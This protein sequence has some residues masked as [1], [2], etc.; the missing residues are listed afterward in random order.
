MA[1]KS[2]TMRKTR[3]SHGQIQSGQANTS[4]VPTSKLQTR[5]GSSAGTTLGAHNADSSTRQRKGLKQLKRKA[6][7]GT[8]RRQ[9][10]WEIADESNDEGDKERATKR[11]RPAGAIAPNPSPF[12][13]R[14]EIPMPSDGR[15]DLDDH[16]STPRARR[17]PSKP[18]T[19]HMPGRPRR[20][21]AANAP[22]TS[23]LPVREAPGAGYVEERDEVGDGESREQDDPEPDNLE[24]EAETSQH[25]DADSEEGDEA[26]GHGQQDGSGS[27]EQDDG[28]AE[29]DQGSA[30]RSPPTPTQSGT[31]AQTMAE[32]Q[33]DR[34]RTEEPTRRRYRT[35]YRPYSQLYNCEESWLS[36]LIFRDDIR[37]LRPSRDPITKGIQ[38]TTTTRALEQIE[39]AI[40][41][42]KV[43][44][45]DADA[46]EKAASKVEKRISKIQEATKFRENAFRGQDLYYYIIPEMITA[47]AALLRALK[48]TT[49]STIA[50]ITP[51]IDMLDHTLLAL[52]KALKWNPR[53]STLA[54]KD[55]NNILRRTRIEVQNA[56]MKIL[57]AYQLHVRR[58]DA[59]KRHAVYLA[60][61]ERRVAAAQ[62]LVE[63]LQ[64]AK[65]AR[66]DES[67]RRARELLA[68]P[69]PS[70]YHAPLHTV[71]QGSATA[72]TRPQQPAAEPEDIYPPPNTY[73]V[74]SAAERQVLVPALQKYRGPN[75]FEEIVAEHGESALH[76]RTVDDVRSQA[77]HFKRSVRA[78]MEKTEGDWS[79]VESIPD[80]MS[81]GT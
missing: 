45:L 8:S 66:I 37:T 38:T 25:E 42:Y 3:Q 23:R 44:N 1:G 46:V 9:D 27:E 53:P 58:L 68:K 56:I 49:R 73:A 17:R 19:Q 35:R 18:S 11:L 63:D 62:K 28:G 54:G 16:P 60:E 21:S 31:R 48:P 71:S 75:R 30:D 55:N 50:E 5:L 33:A 76:G 64:R 80:I 74:L 15:V 81:D 7:F 2:P 14:S 39:R 22:G 29:G 24:D 79:W 12:K 57:H 70:V 77:I 6:S 61:D 43:N 10:S 32:Q 69:L 4:I 41:L 52:N 34:R 47:V 13:G 51:L 72:Q 65:L 26:T 67:R 40:E 36:L 59:A 78:Y 20:H